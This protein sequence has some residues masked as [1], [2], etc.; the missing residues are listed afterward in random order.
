MDAC[1]GFENPGYRHAIAPRWRVATRWSVDELWRIA[2]LWHACSRSFQAPVHRQCRDCRGAT[3]DPPP[4]SKMGVGSRQ[5][6]LRDDVPR[7]M[8]VRGLKTPATGTPS[9]RDGPS[10]RDGVSRRDD[11]LRSF[12]I[13]GL[14]LVSISGLA[15]SAQPTS[16]WS[17]YPA[18]P[19]QYIR[20]LPGQGLERFLVFRFALIREHWRFLSRS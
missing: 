7:W 12:G 20:L 6:S 15:W 18:L 5:T 11:V 17:A 13:S 1:P 14:A 2:E 10:R 9:L 3:F 4:R 8:R 16:A 19:G